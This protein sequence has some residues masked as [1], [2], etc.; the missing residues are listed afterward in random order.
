MEAML[1]AAVSNNKRPHQDCPA[2]EAS[3]N[4]MGIQSMPTA[5]NLTTPTNKP[6]KRANMRAK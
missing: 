4:L 1:A 6:T 2:N 3:E 5:D